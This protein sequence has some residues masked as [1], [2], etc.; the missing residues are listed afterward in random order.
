MIGESIHAMMER[1]RALFLRRQLDRDLEEEIRF[2]LEQRGLAQHGEDA[3]RRFGNPTQYKE[4]LRE[5]WSI[6]WIEVLGQDL[7]YAAGL[8]VTT[9]RSPVWRLPPLPLAL[10]PTPRC[11]AS[12]E[13]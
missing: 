7:R 3:R 9:R 10:A 2:H 5:M 8:S 6:R 12:S 11:T 1:I 13:P 4:E